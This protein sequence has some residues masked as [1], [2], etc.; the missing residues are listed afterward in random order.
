MQLADLTGHDLLLPP[1][2]TALRDELEAAARREGVALRA[3]AEVDGVNLL[4]S[5]VVGGAGPAV[6]PATALPP[7]P[8]QRWRIV[9]LDGLAPREVGLATRRRTV[10]SAAA[11]AVSALLR[12]VV[13]NLAGAQPGVRVRAA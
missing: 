6:L 11:R 5:L 12:E 4:A 1:H 2:G 3:G 9:R 8:R 13:A 10:A 7:D